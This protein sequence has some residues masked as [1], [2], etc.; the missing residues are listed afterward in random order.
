MKKMSKDIKYVVETANKM[1]RS[2]DFQNNPDERSALTTLLFD[3]LSKKNMY[4]GF[5]YFK[6]KEGMLVLAGEET[7]LIQFYTDDKHI[8]NIEEEEK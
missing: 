4:Y 8:V 1:L 7:S 6:M 3:V 5:N 2:E